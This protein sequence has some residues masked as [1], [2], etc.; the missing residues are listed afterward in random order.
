LLDQD[1]YRLYQESPAGQQAL[2]REREAKKAQ[3]RKPDKHRSRGRH[4]KRQ[5]KYDRQHEFPKHEKMLRVG[6]EAFFERQP[7]QRCA[8]RVFECVTEMYRDP[9][10]IPKEKTTDEQKTEEKQG[11]QE[12]PKPAGEEKKPGEEST[13]PAEEKKP[14]EESTKPPEEPEGKKEPAPVPP[15]EVPPGY[16]DH[17][18]PSKELVERPY[19]RHSVLDNWTPLEIATFEAAIC[20]HGKDFYEVQKHIPNKS[21]SECVEFFYFWKRTL[22]YKLWKVYGKETQPLVAQR[23]KRHANICAKMDNFRD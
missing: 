6:V 5:R 18:Y 10:P 22:H 14:G 9:T 7:W 19:K 4:K 13:K 21:T 2:R 11:G 20:A 15:P 12:A 3:K 16:L 8:N 23:K 17:G 1:R